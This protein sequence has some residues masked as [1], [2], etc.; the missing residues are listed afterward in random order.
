MNMTIDKYSS[1][2]I[3][4]N[5]HTHQWPYSSMAILINGHIYYNPIH[6]NP[7]SAIAIFSNSHIQQ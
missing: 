4:I 7:Y 6:E 2:A 1:M 5:G 3:L